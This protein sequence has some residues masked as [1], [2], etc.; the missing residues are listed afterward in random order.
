[1][2]TGKIR[3]EIGDIWKNFWEVRIAKLIS[4]IEHI[5]YLIFIKERG[6]DVAEEGLFTIRLEVR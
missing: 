6:K 3:D 5:T 4:I 2:V 1:M